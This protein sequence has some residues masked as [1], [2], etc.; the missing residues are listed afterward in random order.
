MKKGIISHFNGSHFCKSIVYLIFYVFLVQSCVWM[1]PLNP[2]RY[3]ASAPISSIEKEHGI[4]S[5]FIDAFRDAID[6]FF[7]SEAYAAPP[8]VICVPWFPSDLFVPHETWP[9]KPTILKGIARDD[10]KNLSGGTFYWEYGDGGSSSPAIISNPDNLSITY[11]YNVQP[12][13]LIIARLYVTDAAGEESSDEYR[14]L[15]REK[16]LDLEINK[17][18]DDGLWWLYTQKKKPVG[19]MPCLWSDGTSYVNTT[20]SAVQAYEINGHMETGDPDEDPYVNVVRGGIDSLLITLISR[21]IRLQGGQNPDSNGNGIGLSVNTSYPIY[22]TGA[23]MDALVASGAPDEIARAGGANVI[24]RH[25]Q[26]IVQDMVDMYAWGQTDS[27]NQLGGW[28]YS[29]NIGADNSAAQ[30]GAIGMIAAERNFGCIV[31]QWVKDRNNLWLNF[32]YN[33]AGYFGYTN[34]NTVNH[35]LSTGACGMVQLCF[36]GK[37]IT[38]SRWVAC[39]RYIAN[40]WNRFLSSNNWLYYSFYA[41]AKS[42]RLAL[43]Q[44]VTHLDITGLDW[45]GDENRGLARHLVNTQNPDGFWPK[46]G[47]D[48]AEPT[49]AC[50]NIIILTRALFEKPPVAVIKANPNPGAV[51]QAIHF[52]ASDSYHMD[53]SKEIVSYL[54]DFDDSDGIDFDHPDATGVRVSTTYGALGDY[55]VSLKVFDNSTPVRFDLTT[56]TIHITIPPHAP[57]AVVGGPYISVVGEEVRLDGSGSYDIDEAQGDSITAWDWESDFEAPY[58]F[59]ESHGETA[60]LPS[61][62]VAGHY[63]IGLRVTDNTASVFPDSGQPNLTHAA[64]GRVMVY[65]VGVA[66]LQA[67]PKETKCQLTWTHIGV[68][69]YDVL[70]SERGPN[71]GFEL[72]GRTDSV[73][74]TYLDY[75][76]EL[77]KDYWY[78]IR[79]KQNGETVLSWPVHIKSIGR[80]RNRPPQITSS[81]PLNAQE[82][83]LYSYDAEAQDPEDNPM[84]YILDLSPNGMIINS[85]TGLIQWTPVFAQVGPN[86]VVVRVMDSLGASATQFFTITVS[87]RPNQAPV[88]D[89]DGPYSGLKGEEIIF[90]GSGSYDPEGDLSLSYQWNF[91]DGAT[92]DLQNPTHTYQATGHFIVSLFVTDSRGATGSAETSAQI[93]E[94][95][96]EPTADVG[97]P[98]TG[99]AWDIITFNGSDSSDPDN[100]PLTYTWNFG[101]STPPATGVTADHIFASAGAYHVSLTVDDSRGGLDSDAINV[102]ISPINQPPV[103][104]FT[105]NNFG[106]VGEKLSFDASSSYDSDGTITAYDWDFGDGSTTTGAIVNHAFNNPGYYSVSL[107]VMDNDA[108]TDTTT[109][110]VHINAPPLITSTPTTTALEDDLYTYDVNANDMDEDKL[111]YSLV[112]APTGMSIDSATGLIQWTPTQTHVGNNSVTVEVNDSKGGIATQSFILAVQNVN[113]PPIIITTSLP[114]GTEDTPYTYGVDAN[115]IDQDPLTYTLTVAPTGM[116][117]DSATGLIQWT[118]IQVHVGDNNVTVQVSD[119]N[120]GFDTQSFIIAVANTNDFP[121]IISTPPYTALEDSLYTYDANAT[122]EDNDT[123]TYALSLSPNGMTIDN[124][125]GL[126]QWKPLQADVGTHNIKITVT[127]G[128]GGSDTQSYTLVVSNV[129]DPPVIITASLPPGTEDYPYAY[130]VD[131][132]DMD[133]DKLTY[134]LTV[135]PTGM[136]IDSAT[137]LIQW[138]PIQVHVGDNNVTVQVSDG[139]GGF[140]TRSFIITVANT[141]DPPEITSI[142][143]PTAL[144][145][146]LYTYDADARDEDMDT[147]T[148]ELSLSPNGMTIDNNSGLIQWKPLQADVGTHNITITVTD[149]HGG[150]DTQSYTLE[151]FNVNDPPLITSNPL[152]GA[153]KDF[154]YTYDVEATDEDE[155]T[156]TYGLNISPTGMTIDSSTGLIQWTPDITQVGPHPVEI[157]VTD[158]KGGSA[159]QSYTLNV[160]AVNREPRITSAPETSAEQDQSYTYD[161]DATDPDT[162]PITFSL[163]TAP[164][165]MTIVPDTGLIQWTPSK[166]QTGANQVVVMASDN[167][168]GTGTQTFTINVQNVNDPP[169]ITSVPITIAA[170]DVLYTYDVEAEDIDGDDIEY[171]IEV[172]P[173][174]MTIDSSTGLIQWTPTPSDL[175]DNTV[176]VVAIDPFAAFDTQEFIIEVL[177]A[178]DDTPPRITN[179]HISPLI[180][181][182]GETTTITIEAMDDVGIESYDLTVNGNTVPLL[183][184]T[185]TYIATTI[186][187]HIAEATVCDTSGNCDT[188]SAGFGVRDPS[189]TTHP[190]VSI[191]S[192]ATDSELTAPTDLIGTAT[193]N[194]LVSYTLEYSEK[195]KNSYT[196]FYM[197]HTEVINDVLGTLDTTLLANGLYDI[198]ITAVDVNGLTNSV[199]VT[200]RVTGDLKVGNFTVTFN[201]LEIP[202]AGIP[203][204]IYRTYDSRA[205]HN[206]GDFGYGWNIDI[207]TIKIEENR[208]MGT[209]WYRGQSGGPFPTYYLQ[210]DGAHYVSITMP[211][212]QVLEFNCRFSPDSSVFYQAWEI[213]SAIYD[214]LPGTYGSLKALDDTPWFFDGS[215]ILNQNGGIYNPSLYQLTTID[216]TIYI[217]DQTEGLEKIT[218]NNGNSLDI[219]S[220]GIIHSSGKSITFTRDAKGRI[221]EITDPMGNTITYDYDDNGD[222]IA[223]TDQEDNTSQYTYNSNHAL[224]DILDPT[225]NRPIRNEYDYDGRLIAHTDAEGNRIEYTHN[226]GTRQE[227]VTDRLGYITVFE[228][229]DN[230]NVTSMTDPLGNL[231][232]YT[233]DDRGNK[234]SETDPLDNTTTYTYDDKDNMLTQ[235][236]P[237]GNTTTY[238]YNARGQV[239]TITDPLENVTKY[240]YDAK[241][242]LLTTKDPLDNVTTYTYASR[243]NLTSTTDPLDNVTSYTYD[244]YGNMLTQTDPL[245]NV[246]TYTYDNNGN[247]LTQTVTRTTLSGTETITTTNVY[248]GHNRIIQTIDPNGN[249]TSTEY[250]AIGKQSVTTDKNGNQTQY[251]YDSRGNLIK[252]TFPDGTTETATYDA[253]GRKVSSTDRAGRTTIHI[254]DKLGRLIKTLYPDESYTTTTYDDAGRVETQTDEREN[255]TTFK[256]DE[257]GRRASI[258]DPLGN[259]TTYAYDKNGN[260]LSMTDANDNTYTYLYDENNRRTRTDFPDGTFTSITY[261]ELG[262]KIAETDQ[263]GITTQFE[264]DPLG[265]LIKVTDALGQETTYT[266]D[267]LGN[268]ISQ[269]DANGN[270]TTWEYDNLGQVTKRTLPL[271]M[272]ETMAYDTA[273]N[274][275]SKTDFNGDTITYIYYNNNRLFLKTYP[276]GSS[277]SFTYT[278]TGQRETILDPRGLT[279]FVYDER[280]RL[281][282]STD[283]DGTVIS[284]TYDDAGNRTSVTVPSGTTTYAFDELNR[285]IKVT[286]PDSGVTTYTY[287][288]VGNRASVTYPNNTKAIYTY[289]TLNRL[290]RLENKRSDDSIIS[291]YDY[292]LGLSGNRTRVQE[293]TGRVVDY[294]YDNLYRLTEESITDPTLGDRLVAYS[295]DPVGNRLSKGDTV[296]GPTD[297]TYDENDRLLTENGTTYTYDNN[298]NTISKTEGSGVTTYSYNYENRLVG[299]QTPVA[300]VNYNY[301]ADGIRVSKS[302]DGMVTN[303]LVDKNR[304]YAQVLEERDVGVWL[305]ASYIYGDDLISMDRSG[306]ISFYQYDG[307]GNTRQLSDYMENITDTYIYDAF[308][309]MLDRTGVTKNNYLYTSEQYDMNIGFYYLRARYYNS[310]IGRFLT[311]DT[312][313]GNQFDPISL[314]KYLYANG[315]PINNIDP[316]GKFTLIQKLNVVTITTILAN[317]GISLL[318]FHTAGMRLFKF[319]GILLSARFDISHIVTGGG[320]IDLLFDL[321]FY[322]FF[323]SIAAELGLDPLSTFKKYRGRGFTVV[324]GL[325]FGLSNPSQLSGF[326]VSAFWPRS[327]LR[328][329]PIIGGTSN[330]WGAMLQFAKNVTSHKGATV[331]F[332]KSFSGPA[333]MFFGTSYRAFSSMLSWN[334]DFVDVEEVVPPIKGYIDQL[335]NIANA[336]ASLGRDMSIFIMNARQALDYLLPGFGIN[337]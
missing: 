240:T 332:G 61:F 192:P 34:K 125:S 103:A 236:D 300:T 165:G 320:G 190:D 72:I 141:N 33:P 160:S 147:L 213:D 180:L 108:A 249:S 275:I 209:G 35:D 102:I 262:C 318:A 66:N 64:Y 97:G 17:A 13:T 266:Y 85:A 58:D 54:W 291:S 119:G 267:E 193:D 225:G 171:S 218:D 130:Y 208:P 294:T 269:T 136:S 227:I 330:V 229:D 77:S 114:P 188:S 244:P 69:S 295:Y 258:I 80:S 75:N 226:I 23:V 135:A 211:D 277:V 113:D 335:I 319:D 21:R 312:Y 299:A 177:R 166:M 81:P 62:A 106:N 39:E 245:G 173:P 43:P 126:I 143:P 6:L 310:F 117:I 36:I 44:E 323:V 259:I 167:K 307:N 305:I 175:G 328:L 51:G 336:L 5:G 203:I 120:G 4:L 185:G 231:T 280:D 198:R 89:P 27:G 14:L 129:N 163:N 297:Y 219:T 70:R 96:R 164:N 311:F 49:A 40:N 118:P 287:D 48:V 334:T 254:Y 176:R 205:R 11:T 131:A 178:P 150:S 109:L 282:Q 3:Y 59:A 331:G 253:E 155:D 301:D 124:N 68:D 316:T 184:N 257:A 264:Y 55:V 288:V 220:D 255:T 329:M 88:S 12:G 134:T 223:V 83:G 99:H 241:G 112:L 74:S 10:D 137:G 100:D 65:D 273:G 274:L 292:T 247:Q 194:N 32:S 71:E 181:N 18:I 315:D 132:N 222:L 276:D 46:K 289:D 121:L 60:V 189:D 2:S 159:T 199:K 168:G 278:K 161:V 204:T 104:Q 200:Y 115:D 243:G 63:D 256:Y 293:N 234:L 9:G 271:G 146:S 169:D 79:T 153:V 268:K 133:L 196:A 308:G 221:S 28:R 38:D 116:S 235:T 107:S 20:A 224:V 149:G 251:E 144:E 145:D 317:I 122:D 162:D 52:D 195:D 123:L 30:W 50:W 29:W 290:I 142:P 303:Y 25:Y 90:D 325:V 187:V 105:G 101:D 265:R 261:D 250:N 283:P 76:V 41:F 84:T 140:D 298:G 324:A 26:N 216:G 246:T 53:P 8:K 217:I 128:H 306:A 47:L 207:R 186:G 322:R 239:L 232:S 333:I 57:T 42:M 286:D 281:L 242:N 110:S 230:G 22:E 272:Y 111:S 233:Y 31:P 148:Y 212:G 152:T 182:P 215:N 95:N 314:H 270:T 24:G 16:T 214:P 1:V 67:R 45:Y 56:L 201:D 285:L 326:G 238:T 284:Y 98:Y 296:E 151:V 304:D 172:S 202:V 154:L 313:Q 302:V 260:Q 179:I 279:T 210:P 15:V 158:G 7:P 156:T 93:G 157:L 78:R 170:V 139:N 37:D 91:G 92:S 206:K 337:E 82:G 86:D 138:T 248:D 87:P 94:P 191:T 228:Y 327:V 73:Y 252:T 263:A 19:S 237:L 127:D 321:K 197:G 174:G 309:I 183:G